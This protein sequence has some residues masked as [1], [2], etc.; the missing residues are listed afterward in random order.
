MSN[1]FFAQLQTR[2]G[3]RL[4]RLAF[5]AGSGKGNEGGYGPHGHQATY[6]ATASV[7]P[8]R[9]QPPPL[10]VGWTQH[11]DPNTQRAYFAERATGRPEWVLP[12]QDQHGNNAPRGESHGHEAHEKSEKKDKGHGTGAMVAAGAP[13]KF[14]PLSSQAAH[15]STLCHSVYFAMLTISVR[16]QVK[17]ETC[18]RGRL[19]SSTLFC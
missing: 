10:P 11:W 14:Q 3:S 6:G 16:K 8:P 5:H 12:V 15:V 13:S 7:K 9:S 19:P 4:T 18:P 17:Q 1:V 2:A